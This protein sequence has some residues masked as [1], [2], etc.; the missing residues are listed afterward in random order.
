[1][2]KGRRIYCEGIQRFSF[3]RLKKRFIATKT[4]SGKNKIPER[5]FDRGRQDWRRTRPILMVSLAYPVNQ[6]L[7]TL[8]QL[9]FRDAKLT[10]ESPEARASTHFDDATVS[11]FKL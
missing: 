6:I 4:A 9:G 10:E 2:V 8:Q 3:L 1:M 11:V 7:Q 5:K